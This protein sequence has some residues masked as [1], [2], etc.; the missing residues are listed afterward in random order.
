M[1][2]KLSI[3]ILLSL[4]LAVSTYCLAKFSLIILRIQDAIEESLD[5]IDERYQSISKILEIPLF[6]DSPQIRQ[7]VND[8]KITRD[9]L[10]KVAKRFATV[11][12]DETDDQ[13]EDVSNDKKN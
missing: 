13:Q 9:S 4:G 11:S 6:Y 8:I 5:V 3:I 12:V 1:D 2:W 10:L 7:V